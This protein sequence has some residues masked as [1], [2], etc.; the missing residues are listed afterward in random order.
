M[1]EV[2]ENRAP[3]DVPWHRWLVYAPLRWKDP[4]AAR[5]ASFGATEVARIRSEGQSWRVI[6][7][8]LTC[9]FQLFAACAKSPVEKGRIGPA[10][11]R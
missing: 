5:G 2:I 7:K 10:K 11:Q 1:G 4:R 9:L 3:A 8:A 6:A